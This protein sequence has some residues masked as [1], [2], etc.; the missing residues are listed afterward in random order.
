MSKPLISVGIIFKNDIRSIERCLKALQPLRDAVPCEVVM[1]DTGSTDGSRE[2]A[3]KYADIL[4]DFPWI[5]DFSAA[6]NAVMDRCSGLWFFAVDTDEYLDADVSELVEFLRSSGEREELLAMVNVRNYN[7]FDMQGNYS[8]F[9]GGR[10]LRMSTGVRYTGSI[11]EHFNYPGEMLAYPLA[12]TTLHHDGYA[13]LHAGGEKGEE[14]TQR[15]L[16]MIRK[17]LEKDPENLLLRMQLIESGSSSTMPDYEEQIRQAVQM[18]YDKR[19]GWDHL[20]PAI[21]RAAIYTA[22]HLELP[23]WDEWLKYAEDQF[24]DSMFTRLDI[25][26]AAFAHEWNAGKDRDHAL[27]RGE[28]YLKALED[29]RNG[30][31]PMAQV[32]SP[33]QMATPFAECEAQIH[34]INGYCTCQ[35]FADAFK[36]AKSVDYARLGREQT[37]KF[38]S[39]LQDI[40]FRSTLDT[41]SIITDI[42][43]MICSPSLSPDKAEQWRLSLVKVCGRTFLR[44]NIK[45]ERCK[46]DF[47]RY[48]YSLCAPLRGK[49]E[50][51]TAAA[52]M[53]ME[54]CAEIE[55]A[56]GEVRDWDAFS[57]HALAHALEQGARFPL[58]DRPMNVEEMDSLASR[59]TAD[60]ECF[61][62]LALHLAGTMDDEDWLEICWGRSLLMAAVR[63]YPWNGEGRDEEQGMAIAR[64]FA[65]IEGKFLPRCYSADVLREDRLFA[66]PPMHRFGWYCGQAFEALE[67]DGAAAFV[68]LL[69]SGLDACEGVKNMVEF[70][71][72]QIQQQEKAARIAAAPSELIALANQVKTMLA[73]FE[74]DDPAVEELKNSPAYQ[75]VAWLIEEPAQ[76]AFGT[77][78]Q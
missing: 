45:A 27:L 28:R 70:L 31:D 49:F 39:A 77:P 21:M 74:P 32:T 67:K 46:E 52:I 5:D 11:H 50:V 6:R 48:A 25:Q 68:R 19:S 26:Y 69:R 78:I 66:L 35:R 9:S 22:E 51:G 72:N 30:V 57:I 3:E 41:A 33:L 1:A 43:E 24:P 59:L 10:I 14:K 12:H 47:V 2:I 58:P 56:L 36:L 54:D 60:K 16:R 44:K 53:G 42:W 15:N 17:E 23:E 38:I 29:Y 73:R 13:A 7:T 65:R 37:E 61:F 75:Q 40:H 64:A 8:D 34:I 4:F 18:V 55:T 63:A 62:P 20:G 76:L 71:L